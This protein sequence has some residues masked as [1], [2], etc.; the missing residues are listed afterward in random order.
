MWE[1]W[2]AHATAANARRSAEAELR[3]ADTQVKAHEATHLAVAGPYARG[4][5]EY[6]YVLGPNGERY[7]VGGSVRVDLEP[8]P[9]DPEATL[10][11]A[12]AIMRAAVSPGAPSA[13]DMRIA[14]EAYRMAAQAQREISEKRDSTP[15]QLVNLQA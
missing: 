1:Q 5:A 6:S 14:A 2:L 10:R 7:A 3:G 11:K 12:Q 9:G 8:V 15:G 13:A 4:G